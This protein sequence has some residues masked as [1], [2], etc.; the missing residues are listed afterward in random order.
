MLPFVALAQKNPFT[1]IVRDDSAP[2]NSKA[3]LL[4]EIDGKPMVDSARKIN[5]MITF[6]GTVPSY[7]IT[8]RLWGHNASVGYA[9]GHTPDELFF[10]LEKGT[11]TISTKDSVKKAQV[12]GTKINEDGNRF[13]AF[14]APQLNAIMELNKEGVLA[15]LAKTNTPAFEAGYRPRYQKGVEAYR[16]RLLQ[17]VKEN[18]ASYASLGALSQWGGA[19]INAN[20]VEPLFK[21]LTSE[22]QNTKAGKELAERIHTASITGVGLMAP[23]F[24]QKDTSGK[25]VSLTD[26][27]GKYVLLDFWASWCGPCRAENPNY[28]KAYQQFKDKGFTILGVSLDKQDARDAWLAAIKKD[29][30]LWPQVS[31][32]KYWNNSAA[33]LYD[34]RSIPQNFL[35]DPS[36]KI[37][38]KN[39]RGEALQRA[40]AQFIK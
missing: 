4:Y 11:I 27:R 23:V 31:D 6:H 39:L 3:L 1:V 25:V 37:I 26:F 40:L 16:N 10:S 9:N 29:G 32:L 38:A 19:N 12:T 18:P 24:T 35:I 8:A 7:P 22:I 28:L 30:L 15:M 33:K 13:R 36:G 2:D 5:G 17:Y 34:I 14:M 21:S 20:E